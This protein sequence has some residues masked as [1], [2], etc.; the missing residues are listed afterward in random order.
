VASVAPASQSDGFF[1]SLA[2]KVGLGA[3]ADTTATAQPIPAKPKV[4]E[5]KPAA[6]PKVTAATAPK[7][8]ETKATDTKAAEPKAAE[9]KQAAARPPLK[10]S[11]SDAPAAPA[12]KDGL[13]AGSAPIVQSSSFDSR[14]SAF[15]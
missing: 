2:R 5:A 14:F 4:I 8:T 7:A 11:V 1:S 6:A 3:A 10:P 12:A 13:V 15:K 9:T